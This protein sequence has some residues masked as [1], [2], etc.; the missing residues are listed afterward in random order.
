MPENNKKENEI[1]DL[2]Q[3]IDLDK[4]EVPKIDPATVVET[5]SENE[6]DKEFK[7]FPDK[8]KVKR[9]NWLKYGVVPAVSAI[10]LVAVSL[11]IWQKRRAIMLTKPTRKVLK[12]T[13]LYGMRLPA[14]AARNGLIPV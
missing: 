9:K 2:E 6:R 11:F 3:G 7:A 5:S 1:D 10:A 8:P 4:M 14:S 12:L 13:S